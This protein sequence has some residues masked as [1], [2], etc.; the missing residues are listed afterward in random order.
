MAMFK[1]TGSMSKSVEIMKLSNQLVK[2]PQMNAVMRQMSE[3]MVKA[4]IMEEMMEDT[5]DS[6][7]LGEDEDELEEEAQGQVDKILFELTDGESEV[8][9]LRSIRKTRQADWYQ[10]LLRLQAN[11]VKLLQILFPSYSLQW[12]RPRSQHP[13]VNR[14]R[15]RCKGCSPHSMVC[16]GDDQGL[17][18]GHG[19]AR[20]RAVYYREWV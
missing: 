13:L 20:E 10:F 12:Q 6:G 14:K 15:K 17:S 5:M 19:L 18:V 9:V 2:L 7:V 1:V 8:V 3:E 11:S 4:G 16:S